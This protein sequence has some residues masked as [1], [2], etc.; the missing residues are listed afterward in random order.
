MCTFNMAIN[1]ISIA[2]LHCTLLSTFPKRILNFCVKPPDVTVF[3]IWTLDWQQTIMAM[4]FAALCL[5]FFIDV[6]QGTYVIKQ[7]L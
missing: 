3:F 7:S 5:L 1:Y 4:L 2:N 6:I